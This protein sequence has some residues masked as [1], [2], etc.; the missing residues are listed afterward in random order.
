[1]GATHVPRAPFQ[2]KDGTILSYQYMGNAHVKERRPVG[3]LFFNMGLP[4]L[5]RG[6]L[7]LE[8]GPGALEIAGTGQGRALQNRDIDWSLTAQRKIHFKIN[9]KPTR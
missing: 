4:T 7:Y 2:Y 3:C 9:P 6:R 8:T 1:M 5:V